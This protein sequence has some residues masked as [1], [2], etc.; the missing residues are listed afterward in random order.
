M[1][2]IPHTKKD[3]ES[4]LSV[5]GVKSEDDIFE[6]IPDNLRRKEPLELHEPMSE[7]EIIEKIKNLSRQTAPS[8]DKK[9]FM[10]AGSYFHNIPAVVP[11]LVSRSE[12]TTS[13][14]PYQPEVSQGTLQAVYEYQTLTAKLLGMDIANASMYDGASALAEA[15]LMSF[16]IRKKLKKVA[17]SMSVHPLYRKV[18]ETYFKPTDFEIEYIPVDENGKTDLLAAE[19]IKDCAAFAVQS[20]N[21]FGII[22]E[23]D[24]ISKICKD[25]NCLF[26]SSFTEPFAFG[27]YKPAGLYDADIVCG[28]GQS[29]GI[30]QSCGGPGLGMFASKKDYM[31]SMPGRLCGQT[32]DT[33]GKRG[34]VLTISTREQHIRREKATSNICSNQGLCATTAVVFMSCLGKNGLKKISRQNHDKAFYLKSRLEECGFKDVFKNSCFFNEFVLKA[35]DGFEAAWNRLAE[36]KVIAGLPIGKDYQ[37][38]SGCYLFCATEA[39]SKENIDDFINLVKNGGK[40]NG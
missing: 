8:T 17:V 6:G 26:I 27:M 25:K 15:L 10:G 40:S 22:E 3:V 33:D 19:K 30:P 39:F 4:M 7:W 31:R 29:M 28:E 24:K 35:P 1:H 21:F 32:V 34:F 23:N 20:P 5:I 9:I 13:Y 16:R 2:Y 38:L 12:F 11:Y 36:K 14:T 18:V 37:E